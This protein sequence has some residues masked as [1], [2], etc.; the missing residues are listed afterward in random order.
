MN[1]TTF[2]LPKRGQTIDE[3]EDA[4]AVDPVRGRFA[5]AD[6]AS[7]CSFAGEWATVLVQANLVSPVRWCERW[8]DWLPPLQDR[9]WTFVNKLSL[10]WYG[11]NKIQEGTES[12]FLNLVLSRRGSW[13]WWSSAV[14]DSC[15]FHIRGHQL[16]TTF[17][18]KH[19]AEFGPSPHLVGTQMTASF[20]TET[21]ERWMCGTFVAGD[22]FLLA[23]DALAEYL[24]RESEG[25]VPPWLWLVN[26]RESSP[27]PFMAWVEQLRDEQRLRDDDVT[28][29]MIRV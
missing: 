7:S 11:R 29:A 25:G 5:I 26:Q 28:L 16:L 13:R 17:P 10:P 3:C 4:V 12:T 15:L 22:V 1:V 27:K 23:T 9:W 14:G 21:M 6:G 18:V 19:S 24:L 8:T 2:S 20:V